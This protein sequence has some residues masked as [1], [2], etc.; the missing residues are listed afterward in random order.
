MEYISLIGLMFLMVS[1]IYGVLFNIQKRL[2][3]IETKLG[4]EKK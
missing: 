1:P 2:T 4:C 3:K